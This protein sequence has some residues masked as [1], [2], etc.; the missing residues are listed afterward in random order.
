MSRRPPAGSR[1]RPEVRV[2]GRRLVGLAVVA[3]VCAAVAVWRRDELVTVL[4]ALR[5][6]QWP[7][8]AA[9]IAINV[10]S[11]GI[12]ALVWGMVLAR[13]VPGHRL[14]YG[15]YGP[16]FAIG[17]VANA[18]LPVRVGELARIAVLSRALPRGSDLWI[19][20]GGS[21]FA[22]HLLDV[23]P[24]AALV[25]YVVYSADVPAWA[26]PALAVTIGGGAALLALV[27]AAVRRRSHAL[28]Q[29]GGSWL[30][31]LAGH[32]REGLALFRSP[33][34]VLAAA[35]VQSL[36][37]AAEFFAV[38]FA[39][40][41]FSI[42]VPL[43]A[44][45][46]VLLLTNVATLFP[47]WPGNVGLLQAAV[48][49]PLLAYGVPYPKG[50][51]FGVGLQ[52]IE[53]VVALGL[54]LPALAYEG[55]TL[56][57]LRRLPRRDGGDV[58]AVPRLELSGRRGAR[59]HRPPGQG[60]PPEERG[61]SEGGAGEQDEEAGGEPEGDRA[62]RGDAERGERGRRGADLGEGAHE[63]DG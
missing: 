45:G 25:V 42:D 47:L 39:F 23:L 12:R 38:V 16:A 31:R 62:I 35:G 33:R 18:V 21:V 2:S 46:A 41:A 54:G 32:L 26:V 58:G 48:A 3:A 59:E 22:Q 24:Q 19:N 17:V 55:V 7:W 27:M 11:V 51:L 1:G 4:G 53:L 40:E 43:A 52:A 44:A 61:G 29:P 60:R 50:L 13:A 20:V 56:A 30:E 36:G 8:V 9:A 5:A 63:A 14:S 10:A 37:W 49:L 57:E 34:S 15:A 6:V 28:V